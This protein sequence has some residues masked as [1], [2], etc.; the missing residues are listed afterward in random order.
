MSGREL[1][2][3]CCGSLGSPSSP[4]V[5][6]RRQETSPDIRLIAYTAAASKPSWHR[7]QS[8]PGLTLP[9]Q[10][11]SPRRRDRCPALCPSPPSWSAGAHSARWCLLGRIWEQWDVVFSMRLATGRQILASEVVSA[12]HVFVMGDNRER[13]SDSRSWVQAPLHHLRDGPSGSSGRWT[14]VCSW[15][16]ALAQGGSGIAAELRVSET[17]DKVRLLQFISSLERISSVV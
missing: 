5:S 7:S 17:D 10:D 14:P 12:K 2:W 16:T 9:Q 4:A 6:T 15:K 3:P 13:S 1:G 8:E 11:L